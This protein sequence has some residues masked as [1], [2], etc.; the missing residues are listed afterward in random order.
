MSYKYVHICLYVYIPVNML[1]FLCFNIFFC[2][3]DNMPDAVD[4]HSPINGHTLICIYIYIYVYVR[5]CVDVHICFGYDG[6]CYCRR[7]H[8]CSTIIAVTV[9]FISF[10]IIFFSFF[11][12]YIHMYFLNVL[13]CNSSLFGSTLHVD[14]SHLPPVDGC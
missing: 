8:R 1:K 4:F 3:D 12:M 5:V 10:S 11:R 6:C 13:V 7:R 9:R 2:F 14:I